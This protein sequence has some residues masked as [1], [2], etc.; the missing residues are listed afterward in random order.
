MHSY[1]LYY[2]NHNIS[3]VL[4]KDKPVYKLNLTNYLRYMFYP[5]LYVLKFNKPQ[6]KKKITVQFNS[7]KNIVKF[8]NALLNKR[9]N[10]SQ[11]SP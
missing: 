10:K 2:P 4:K 6:Q 11:V 5:F 9:I 7:A 3:E 1:Q 8:K